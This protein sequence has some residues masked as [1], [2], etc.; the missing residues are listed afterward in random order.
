[1]YTMPELLNNTVSIGGKSKPCAEYGGWLL[2]VIHA[3]S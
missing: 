2:Q 1:M 3:F